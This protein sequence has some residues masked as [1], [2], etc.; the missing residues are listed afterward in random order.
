MSHRSDC[1]CQD[2][3]DEHAERLR[4]LAEGMVM[5]TD[6]PAPVPGPAPSPDLRE[7]IAR[8][9][10]HGIG[11]GVTTYEIVDRIL[12]LLPQGGPAPT[13]S[14]FDLAERL[15]AVMKRD[16]WAALHAHGL[17][18]SYTE[19]HGPLVGDFPMKKEGEP[20]PAAGSG[21][22]APD[23]FRA[24]WAYWMG[25]DV[26]ESTHKDCAEA[27]WKAAKRGWAPKT[28][29]P[30]R[31]EGEG[32]NP[33]SSSPPLPVPPSD[34]L[35]RE[36]IEVWGKLEALSCDMVAEKDRRLNAEARAEAAE[37]RVREL[38]ERL[39][40]ARRFLKPQDHDTAWVD[41][42]LPPAPTQ[43]NHP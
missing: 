5:P 42:V 21:R 28:A 3:L 36:L 6:L 16:G 10:A 13:E 39:R 30:S 8:T 31:A 9:I 38:E 11:Q 26:G 34:P 22:S 29:K 4:E 43:E 15:H 12:A 33:S 2:C 7:A 32:S 40:Y 25:D 35:R 19:A 17:A 23:H 20:S 18:I 41:E 1:L 24:W 14:V 27:A 37:A